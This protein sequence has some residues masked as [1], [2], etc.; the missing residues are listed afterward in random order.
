MSE[1]NVGF[2]VESVSNVAKTADGMATDGFCEKYEASAEELLVMMKD[3]CR[4]T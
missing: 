1:L 2:E 4:L 3:T